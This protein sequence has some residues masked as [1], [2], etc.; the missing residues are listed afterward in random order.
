MSWL[1]SL[2]SV[3][4]TVFSYGQSQV[5]SGGQLQKELTDRYRQVTTRTLRLARKAGLPF[6]KNY[7]NGQTFQLQEIDPT[8]H[9]IYYRTHNTAA[10]L[11]TQTAS[12]Y[13]GGSLGL[14][15]S[16]NSDRLRGRLGLWDGGWALASHQEFGGRIRNMEPRSDINDHTTHTA[17]TMIA[18]GL[19]PA[20]RG[21]A[22]GATLSVWN[23][24]NDIPEMATAAKD[25]L[26]SNHAYG[27]VVGW[28]LNPDRVGSDLNQKWEWWGNTVVSTTEDYQF[29]FYNTKA[30][31]ID[32]ILYN[33]PH[34]LVVRSADNKRAETGPPVSVPY[35]IRNT[36]EKSTLP[37]NRNDGFD[38][39]A[40]EATAKNVLTVGAA[41]FADQANPGSHFSIA[42]YSGWG[43]TD[44]GRIKPDLLG[45]GIPILSALATGTAA[46]GTMMGTSMA[47]AN[48]TGSL[49]LLQE[50][51][52]QQQHPN[53]FMRAA[54]LR[55]L[56]LH[57]AT[58]IGAVEGGP[59]LAPDYKQG[60]GL[61]NMRAAAEVLLNENKAHSL[62]EAT[63]LQG[64]TQTYQVVAQGNEPLVV[65]ISW[66][67]PEA[68][69]TTV[70][71]RN[72]NNRTPKLVNDLDLRLSDEAESYYPW[73]LNPNQPDQ[74]ATPGD[75][76]RDNLEQVVIQHPI[77]GRAYTIRIN[78]KGELRYGAQPF[79]MAVSGLRRSTC[80]LSVGLVPVTDTTYCLGKNLTLKAALTKMAT[81]EA[82]ASAVTYEW[83][84]NGKTIPGQTTSIYKVE[85]PGVYTLR[86]T[87]KRG[88]SGLSAKVTIRPVMQSVSL[89]PTEN[90]LICPSRPVV[91]LTTR[92]ESGLTYEWLRNGEVIG[93][94]TQAVYVANAPGQYQVR[95]NRQGCPVTSS[96]VTLESNAQLTSDITPSDAEL[97][98]PT[99]SSV[100]L[101]VPQ[102]TSYQ[103]QWLRNEQE[104]PNATANRWL[105]NK[106][107][108]YRVRITQ[109]SC[110][111]L[112]SVRVV[113]WADG[114]STSSLPD[115]L[116]QYAPVDSL[117]LLTP[118][119][120]TDQ[121][122]A[123]YFRPLTKTFIS[124][125]YN[126]SGAAVL[127]QIPFADRDGILQATISVGHLPPGHYFLQIIDGP[128]VRRARLIKL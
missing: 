1:V 42:S 89:S 94:G 40:A 8:G 116:L 98:I 73:T 81:A 69:A 74:P 60:W 33:N 107:G 85:Q 52:A 58:R 78:H 128:R 64:A 109:Q 124:T 117:L 30:A 66:T 91:W 100:R 126:S 72:V 114:N 122:K 119:P 110:K 32:R 93:Q 79:S 103:Y 49:L 4:V 38:V 25:L 39:I 65:T 123:H 108:Q 10:G 121:V 35:Y 24:E 97:S 21:M 45:V 70:S 76:V 20:A 56:V 19:N 48:V 111:A 106:P 26:L 41:E 53:P 11:L 84:Q 102:T 96:V 101:Q 9:P 14:T 34:Y 112:S 61:L 12:L 62:E 17:G 90:Q 86:A 55:T 18:K 82:V 120:A 127:D 113:R 118:N 83:L 16:G 7:S 54:T 115:S 37:R 92:T 99:G 51:Y 6:R 2:L 23:F 29:G 104:V 80:P 5:P 71:S 95:I 44:D 63:L 57:T 22:S 50:L 88:C 125:L 59:V 87:D 47:A 46:Y 75:N 15:L 28:V 77:P 43:P 13:A 31:D 27:P 105:A 3:C 67:D 68:A 36:N